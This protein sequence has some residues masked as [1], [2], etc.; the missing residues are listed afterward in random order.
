[1]TRPLVSPLG[2]LA[3]A[4]ALGV[5]AL[6]QLSKY[7]VLN[8]HRLPERISTPVLPFFDLT[9]VWNRGVSFGLLRADEDVGRWLLAAFSLIVSGALIVWAR[10]AE[11]PWTALALGLVIGG[12]LGNLIDRVRFGAVADFLDFTDLYFPWIFNVADSAITVGVIILLIDGLLTPEPAR[13][14]AAR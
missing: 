5:I 8:V 3:Y 1:M 6:D 4:L 9:M 13:K 11:R 2:A 7:W 12:A 14:A 10:K